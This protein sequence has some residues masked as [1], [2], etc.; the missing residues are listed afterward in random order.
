MPL[1]G[2]R[3]LLGV[4]CTLDP[5]LIVDQDVETGHPEIPGGF[6]LRPQLVNPLLGDELELAE[7]GY[8]D[9]LDLLDGDGLLDLFQ[10]LVGVVAEALFQDQEVALLPD[11]EQSRGTLLKEA[12]GLAGLAQ[13]F[14]A[15]FGHHHD[16]YIRIMMIEDGKATGTADGRMERKDEE[17]GDGGW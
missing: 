13:N 17:S 5:L 1:S 9:I 3:V 14:L 12:A 4:V 10:S 16:K 6:V 15:V 8:F 11:R 7:G 2:G